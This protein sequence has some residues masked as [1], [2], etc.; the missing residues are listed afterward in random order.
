[1]NYDHYWWFQSPWK[2]LV[3]WDDD[4]PNIWKNKECSKPPIRLTLVD[5]VWTMNY[6]AK[7]RWIVYDYFMGFSGTPIDKFM[8]VKMTIWIHWNKERREWC[9]L[10]H[11]NQLYA[12]ATQHHPG[13]SSNAPWQL[14]VSAL[15]PFMIAL[16]RCKCDEYVYDIIW[17]HMLWSRF[18]SS[19]QSETHKTE[20]ISA[21][22]GLLIDVGCLDLAVESKPSGKH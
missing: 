11:C 3:N 10:M 15:G 4:V 6:V 22:T 14:W 5:S 16:Y 17:Y 12:P 8:S 2:I 13:R 19:N 20:M 21:R 7:S 9:R 18:G 1:M